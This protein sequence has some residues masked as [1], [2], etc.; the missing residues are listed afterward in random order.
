[1]ILMVY[2]RLY[3]ASRT[4]KQK[5]L[6]C[7]GKM[8]GSSITHCVVVRVFW[9]LFFYKCKTLVVLSANAGEQGDMWRRAEI[10]LV[11]AVNYQ[12]V[13]EGKSGPGYQGDIAIDDVSFTPSCQP[14]STATISPTLP[15]VTPSPGCNPGEF[16]YGMRTRNVFNLQSVVSQNLSNYDCLVIV[17]YV[18]FKKKKHLAFF[19]FFFGNDLF[20]FQVQIIQYRLFL[21]TKVTAMFLTSKTPHS[22]VKRFQ[23]SW[24]TSLL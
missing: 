5:L 12:V 23:Q 16:R 9:F 4:K 11:S 15:T 17:A 22:S 24:A 19:F 21:C 10:L 14:D 18:V 2:N 6:V 1:M 8:C 7:T 20:Y 3:C 13:I